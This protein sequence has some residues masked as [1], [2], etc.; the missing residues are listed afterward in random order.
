MR[1]V[2]VVIA[3]V[4]VCF[5]KTK[6]INGE[7]HRTEVELFEMQIQIK[8]TLKSALFSMRKESNANNKDNNEHKKN[9]FF[10]FSKEKYT[11]TNSQTETIGGKILSCA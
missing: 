9:C 3:V 8:K 6:L 10:S 4:V 2:V 5:L 1:L 7:T 11:K